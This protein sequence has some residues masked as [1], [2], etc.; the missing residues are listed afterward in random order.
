[1]INDS[2]DVR[3]QDFEHAQP[4]NPAGNTVDSMQVLLGEVGEHSCER[5][6]TPVRHADAQAVSRVGN[7]LVHDRPQVLTNRF[8]RP[9]IPIVLVPESIEIRHKL[10]NFSDNCCNQRV[11][12]H[13][14]RGSIF[15][16]SRGGPGRYAPR[17]AP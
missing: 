7:Q 1:M 17:H 16:P 3:P 2:V 9:R 12:S 14:L 13:S 15:L 11:R 8:A 5:M 4:P 6:M 10:V